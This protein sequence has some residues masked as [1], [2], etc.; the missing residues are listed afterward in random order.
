MKRGVILLEEVSAASSATSSRRDGDIISWSRM[1]DFSS[2]APGG[3]LFAVYFSPGG[4]GDGGLFS[5]CSSQ[6]LVTTPA[7]FPGSLESGVCSF[8]ANFGLEVCWLEQAW[9]TA[10][11][12]GI[13]TR[14]IIKTFRCW[15]ILFIFC[16]HTAK[17]TGYVL[18]LGVGGLL[19]YKFYRAHR[20]RCDAGLPTY[21]FPMSFTTEMTDAG[22]I[23]DE[24]EEV[25]LACVC[26]SSDV[27]ESGHL[28]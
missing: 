23:W 10:I 2:S 27:K 11:Q 17:A 1:I 20:A 8:S 21:I 24:M 14:K 6:G 7:S 26:V 9:A 12:S 15:Y 18:L 19:C 13:Y 16:T 22:E 3:I 4:G 5:S 25:W 28:E